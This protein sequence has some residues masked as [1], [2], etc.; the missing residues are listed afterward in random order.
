MYAVSRLV[1]RSDQEIVPMLMLYT[2]GS[3]PR[4]RAS[5]V[6]RGVTDTVSS[7]EK[8]K[9]LGTPWRRGCSDGPDC[10]SRRLRRVAPRQQEVS[11]AQS[12]PELI[13]QRSTIVDKTMKH[14]KNLAEL[15]FFFFFNFVTQRLHKT[16]FCELCKDVAWDDRARAS[17]LE[18]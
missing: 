1:C 6:S 8:N 15:F 14:V 16:T 18:P 17:F 9:S 11:L 3:W 7:S 5:T 4:G 10:R 12:S 2:K 13:T